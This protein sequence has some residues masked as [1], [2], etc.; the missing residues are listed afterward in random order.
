MRCRRHAPPPSILCLLHAASPVLRVGQPAVA[1]PWLARPPLICLSV[2][3]MMYFLRLPTCQ[4]VVLGR[5]RVHPA[6]QSVPEPHAA[7]YTFI[8]P[9]GI[10][11]SQIL[12]QSA[13]SQILLVQ[14]LSKTAHSSPLCT[15]T[16][17]RRARRCFNLMWHG[18][19]LHSR[20]VPLVL[21]WG[22][23]GDSCPVLGYP[24]RLSTVSSMYST[25][26]PVACKTCHDNTCQWCF[27]YTLASY[28]VLWHQLTERKSH[29][30]QVS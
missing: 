14:Y 30:S 8:M 22:I 21:F 16:N 10:D 28:D 13:V 20:R 9:H 15:T 6:L 29:P 5:A 3:P 23:P 4:D 2:C 12:Q 11:R 24:W 25:R 7:E 19:D 27:K 1:F 17:R 18:I 26:R